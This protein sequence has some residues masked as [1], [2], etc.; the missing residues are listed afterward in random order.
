VTDSD[1]VLI[2]DADAPRA[3]SIAEALKPWGLAAIQCPDPTSA[4][5]ALAASTPSAVLVV[6]PVEAGPFLAAESAARARK[7]PVL[8]VLGT[9]GHPSSLLERARAYDDWVPSPVDGSHLAA[10]ILGLA[11]AKDR[12]AAI[13]PRFLALTVHDLRTPLNVIGLTIR[14]IH[15]SVPTKSVELE[16]DLTFLQDNA[17]Q[18]EKMLAQLGDF[19]RLLEIEAPGRS[20]STRTVPGWRSSTPCPTR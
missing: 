6:E 10:R 1:R 8:A 19:C 4:G 2:F 15:Q 20:R 13:D 11:K 5:D 12:S 16:E 17:R 18:I 7:V 9:S 14:A 3:S